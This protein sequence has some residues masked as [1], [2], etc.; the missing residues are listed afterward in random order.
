MTGGRLNTTAVNI[1][2]LA[3]D[4]VGVR[5]QQKRKPADAVPEEDPAERKRVL[6]VLAQRRYS[7]Y[8]RAMRNVFTLLLIKINQDRGR[9][10]SRICSR[11]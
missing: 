9:S 11:R 7:E 5:K 4:A 3:S 2:V 6:N 10:R 8:T 1:N